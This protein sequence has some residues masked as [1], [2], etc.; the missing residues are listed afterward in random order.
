MITLTDKHKTLLSK[1][2]PDY[3]QYDYINDL[4]E[5]LDDV[6]LNSLDEHDEGTDETTIIARLYDEIYVAN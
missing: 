5:V 3:E 1:Y 4:L 2:I 6:M